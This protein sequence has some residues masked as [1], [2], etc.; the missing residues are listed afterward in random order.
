MWTETQTPFLM[1]AGVLADVALPQLPA[2]PSCHHLGI[3]PSLTP[4]S[5]SHRQEPTGQGK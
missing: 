1:V 4:A 3:Q 5:Y 2:K